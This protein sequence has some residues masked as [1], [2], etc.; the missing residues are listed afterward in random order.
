MPFSIC[1][2][3]RFLIQ[4]HVTY[5]ASPFFKVSLACWSGF[6]SMSIPCLGGWQIAGQK[7]SIAPPR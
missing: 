3:R 6:G 4:R 1:P 5:Y 7:G 2:F